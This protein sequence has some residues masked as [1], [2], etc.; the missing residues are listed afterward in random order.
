MP[1]RITARSRSGRCENS[2]RISPS[3]TTRETHVSKM[4]GTRPAIDV[5]SHLI[6]P[7]PTDEPAPIDLRA[8]FGNDYP[9]ELEI[10]SGKG[11]FV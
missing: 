2:L 3:T 8:L 9:V 4:S 10:G 11:L 1:D 6:D 5:S 7:T